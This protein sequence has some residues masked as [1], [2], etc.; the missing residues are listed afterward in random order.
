[1]V[2]SLDQLEELFLSD[3]PFINGFQ[4]ITIADVLA[5]CEVEQTRMTGFEPTE[6]RPMLQAWLDRVKNECNPYYEEAHQ[7][8]RNNT[9]KNKERTPRKTL[10]TENKYGSLQI[11]TFLWF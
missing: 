9:E 5:A 7:V 3:G 10:V 6:G 1:M 11:D 4:K 8:V 2:N